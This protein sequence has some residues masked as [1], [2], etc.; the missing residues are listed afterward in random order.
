MTNE[1]IIEELWFA[2]YSHGIEE[3]VRTTLEELKKLYPAMDYD[4]RLIKAYYTH[5]PKQ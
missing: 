5:K 4:D 3:K 2:A 1:Q